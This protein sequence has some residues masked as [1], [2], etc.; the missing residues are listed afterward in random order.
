MR[1]LGLWIIPL[2][3][4]LLL[5]GAALAQS[6]DD[7][8]QGVTSEEL[9]HSSSEGAAL[10]QS[11]DDGGPG[12]DYQAPG[13]HVWMGRLPSKGELRSAIT[14]ARSHAKSLAPSVSDAP[15]FQNGRVKVWT[16]RLP[17]PETLRNMIRSGGGGR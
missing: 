7:E 16:G 4:G 15:N 12:R 9:I 3:G 8:E 10:A 6:P 1:R 5:T 14:Q 13:V 2:I 11:P 17:K